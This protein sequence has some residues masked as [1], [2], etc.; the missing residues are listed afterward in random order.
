MGLAHRHLAV[1]SGTGFLAPQ[2][3][4][5]THST[6]GLSLPCC[7][8]IL[9]IGPLCPETSG[10]ALQIGQEGPGFLT[11][12]AFDGEAEE[13][14]PA[15]VAGLAL[16]ARAA[17]ALP[18]R[19]V[20]LVLQGAQRVALTAVAGEDLGVSKPWATPSP[21]ATAAAGEGPLDHVLR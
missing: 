13:A 1:A 9:P 2:P 17:G 11:P 7:T 3:P 14:Q 8:A 10:H 4:L 20:A 21:A 6:S 12:A 16:N 19:G 15:S 18:S 5:L